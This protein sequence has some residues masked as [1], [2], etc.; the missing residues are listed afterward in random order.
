[1]PGKEAESLK[2][3]VQSQAAV[4]AARKPGPIVASTEGQAPPDDKV[5]A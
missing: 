1:M 5:G 3:A 2:R 4:Q